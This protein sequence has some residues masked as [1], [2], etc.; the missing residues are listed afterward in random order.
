MTSKQDQ[1][2]DWF[3]TIFSIIYAVFFLGVI[4][5]MMVLS[6]NTSETKEVNYEGHKYRLTIH[7]TNSNVSMI[8]SPNCQ[9][10]ENKKI[11]HFH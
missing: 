7:H 2:I 6:F 3:M 9:C 5:F 8:H 11:K 1:I 4:V 10:E